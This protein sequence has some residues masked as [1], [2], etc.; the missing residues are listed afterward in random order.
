MVGSR[1]VVDNFLDF[2]ARNTHRMS[3]CDEPRLRMAVDELAAEWVCRGIP[4]IVLSGLP[5][6]GPRIAK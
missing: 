5:R 6:P 1:P 2:M 4:P 3:P